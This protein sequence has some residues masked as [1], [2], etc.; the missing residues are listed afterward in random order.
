M[1]MPI[2]IMIMITAIIIL[3]IVYTGQNRKYESIL[4]Q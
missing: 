4:G 1:K 2:L 3:Y